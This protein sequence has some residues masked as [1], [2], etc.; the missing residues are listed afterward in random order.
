MKKKIEVPGFIFKPIFSENITTEVIKRQD[1]IL[2]ID[3]PV[4]NKETVI[5]AAESLSLKKRRAHNRNIDDLLD[6]I[7]QVG[8]LWRNRNYDIRK[9]ALEILPMISGQSKKLCEIELDGT[10]V[11]WKKD[12]A[13]EQLRGEIGG[14]QYLEDWIPKRSSRIHAQPRGLVLHNLAGNT[15]NI[16][17]LSLFYGLVTK[18]VNLI[19]LAHEEPYTT[20]KLCESISDVDKKIA[21]EIVAIYWPGR[22]A[23]IFDNLFNSG[24]VNCILAWGGIHSIEAIRRRANRFGIKI[25]DHGPKVSFSVI[26]EEIFES[27]EEMREIAQKLAIDV[28]IWNQKACLSPRVVYIVENPQKVNKFS[29]FS[30]GMEVKHNNQTISENSNDLEERLI[31]IVEGNL[32]FDDIESYM[33][34]SLKLLKN[35]LTER[36]ALGFAKML[37]EG[38]KI[39]DRILPRANLTQADGMEMLRKREYFLMNYSFKKQAIIFTPPKEKLDWTVVYLRKLPNMKEIDMCQNRFVIITRIS[40]INDFLYSIEKEKLHQYL[41][42]ISIYGSDD[43]VKRLADELSLLGAY[44]FPRVGDHN[45]MPIGMPWDGHYPL[46]DMIKWVYIDYLEQ[47]PEKEEENKISIIGTLELEKENEPLDINR[48]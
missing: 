26:S 22:N 34:R 21:K 46:Q 24:L 27:L 44:R 43:F 33:R 7:E 45:L 14:K 23:D 37:A 32:S 6:V 28:A 17:M 41:Q 31:D 38:M 39:T 2:E 16:G 4:F 47:K 36:S 11:L 8:D 35:E 3:F 25:I 5:K 15:F 1:D 40:S 9:E 20:I 48:F 13:E 18:N 29:D 42:T 19:K 12:T 10:L 30:S